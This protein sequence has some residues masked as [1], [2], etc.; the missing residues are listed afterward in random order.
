ME[1]QCSSAVDKTVMDDMWFLEFQPFFFCFS[2]HFMGIFI[3]VE[4]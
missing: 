4:S 1:V 2:F 3:I